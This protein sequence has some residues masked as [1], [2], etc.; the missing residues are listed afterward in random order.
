MCRKLIPLAV[1]GLLLNFFCY[2]SVTA[3]AKQDN[4]E[5]ANKVKASI[6]KLGTGFESRV[7]ITLRDKSELRG[8]VSEIQNDYFI[9]V[10]DNTHVPTKVAYSAVQKVKVTYHHGA[11]NKGDTYKK[12]AIIGVILWFIVGTAVGYS[13]K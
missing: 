8:Y 3:S 10:I 12:V 5:L 13:N 6:A 11:G 1:I 7:K 2:T 4:A 9:V